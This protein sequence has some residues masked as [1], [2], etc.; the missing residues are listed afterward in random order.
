MTIHDLLSWYCDAPDG[1]GDQ[2]D[3]DR[4]LDRSWL[5]HG[6]GE[7]GQEVRAR[8]E[9]LPE[10]TRWDDAVRIVDGGEKYVF[11]LDTGWPA[12]YWALRKSDV[13]AMEVVKRW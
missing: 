11:L 3:L 12:G 7:H 2:D 13:E 4:L 8:V 1:D 10:I 9:S 6:R 5:E